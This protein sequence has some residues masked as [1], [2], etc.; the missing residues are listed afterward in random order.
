MDSG[1][2]QTGAACLPHLSGLISATANILSSLPEETVSPVLMPLINQA[3]SSFSI[4]PCNLSS[5]EAALSRS[6]RRVSNSSAVL[7]SAS[8]STN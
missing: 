5:R 8:V 3:F 1:Y 6:F 7:S 4:S 2:Q